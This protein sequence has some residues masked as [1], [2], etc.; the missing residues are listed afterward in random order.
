[1][2]ADRITAALEALGPLFFAGDMLGIRAL[3]EDIHDRAEDE[4]LDDLIAT[5]DAAAIW[6]VSR[7]RAHAHIA[8]LHA[9]YGYGRLIGGS[10]IIRRAHV[11]SSA[12]EAKYRPRKS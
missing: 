7:Q 10:W 1:M 3:L 11:L 5:A 2:S 6:G 8:R 12:P 4:L 9:K